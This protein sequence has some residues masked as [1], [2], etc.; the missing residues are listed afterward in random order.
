MVLMLL[1]L[2]MFLRLL[3]FLL[4]LKKGKK[5][6]LAERATDTLSRHQRCL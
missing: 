3:L 1:L 2:V 5:E 4:H 6:V